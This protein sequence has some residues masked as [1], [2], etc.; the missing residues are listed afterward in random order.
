MTNHKLDIAIVGNGILGLT[1]AYRL[2]KQNAA[3]NIGVIGPEERYGSATLAAGA[4]INLWAE[5]TTGTFENNAL[6]ERFYLT[7]NGSDLWD[8]FATEL[9]EYSD[10]PLQI[11]RGTYVIRNAKST[12]LE[13]KIYNYILEKLPELNIK[14][15]V[16]NPDEIKWLKPSQDCRAF[17][18][19]WI[20]D[21]RIDSRNVV[22]ALDR[23]LEALGV[24]R[25]HS[26]AQSLEIPQSLLSRNKSKKVLLAN[27]TEIQADQ[28]VL[29]NGAYAQALIDQNPSLRK[30][31]PRLLFGGGSGINLHLP[32]WV[33]K[34]GGLGKEVYD[35][36]CVVRTT[37]RGG[38]CGLHVVPYGDGKFYVGASSGVWM[39][40]DL[41]PKVH[42]VHTLVHSVV[43]EINRTFFHG[44]IEL[45]GN[46]FRPISAD[47]FPLLGETHIQGVWMLNGTKRDGL[48]MSPYLS[49]EMSNAILGQN[50]ALPEIFKPS[51][52]LIPWKTF[53]SAFAETE[54]MYIGADFQH[55]ARHAPYMVDNYHD[56]RRKQI[57][58]I[59][60][61]RK[62][63]NFGIHPELIH[64]YE[65][66][67]F[68][69]LIKH[70]FGK[71]QH[72]TN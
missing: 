55:G 63:T 12:S 40:P 54:S 7:K 29:A 31:I 59:Y 57:E 16:V 23:A 53:K 45:R 26:A 11:K 35:M 56:M 32:D 66:N 20:P 50:H 2:K 65:N 13:D 17:E 30:E 41:Y 19:L 9:S 71:E 24:Q 44:G 14:H 68:Y 6:R 61:R 72:A 46:G 15:K 64:L 25:F 58:V 18:A 3:L 42:G 48:T 39:E 21:G 22:K 47:C 34:Y 5:L 60:D 10:I 8:D 49:N 67:D 37:D 33:E 27:K 69:S 51:R 4:M 1:L 43:H 62:I 52:P 28:I 36:D 70:P 38:A